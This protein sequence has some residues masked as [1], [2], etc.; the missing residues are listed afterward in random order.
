M[1]RL[2]RRAALAAA[3]VVLLVV[4]L[5]V[6]PRSGP[7]DAQADAEG[8][9]AALET[10][11]AGLDRRVRELEHAG[12][13]SLP[14]EGGTAEDD[15][16]AAESDAAVASGDVGSFGNPVPLGQA[17]EIAE[18]WTL[19]VVGTVPDATERV[20]AQNR[21]NDPPAA[22]RQFFLITV[23][24]ANRG[25]EPLAAWTAFTV[26]AVAASSAAYD[27][28]EDRCGVLPDE[29]P[30]AA[31]VPGGTVAGSICFSVTT[32]DAASLVLYTDTAFAADDA[33]VHFALR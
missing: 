20:L 23:A 32:E 30:D 7:A 5:V 18:G 24:I 28:S 14:D 26:S 11:V 33:R 6:V 31:V 22:G 15:E 29:L 25:D 19:R 12:A 9:V 13:P 16:D 8:R 1:S 2:G 17:A 4:P 21:F 3:A 27:A 10:R